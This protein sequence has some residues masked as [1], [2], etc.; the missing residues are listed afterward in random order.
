VIRAGGIVAIPTDTLYGLAVDSFNPHAVARVF[1]TKGRD[2]SRS[3]PL[4]AWDADQIAAH[5]GPLPARALLLAA[6]FW[7]GPL[8]LIVDAARRVPAESTGHT[9]TA[10]VRVPA[11]AVARE[12]CRESGM[13]LTATSANRSG[14]PA[15]DDPDQVAA[16]LGQALD[17]LLDAG[18]T[19]GGAASTIV[20]MTGWPPRLVREGAISWEDVR[21]CLQLV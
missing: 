14:E 10:A 11:H 20:D 3:L 17:M 9:P 1:E 18:K 5:I 21:R 4:I 6:R 8:T 15:T 2:A 12:L 16:T 7:P 13:L 19:P